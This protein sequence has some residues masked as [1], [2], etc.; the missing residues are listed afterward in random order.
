MGGNTLLR[1]PP[2]LFGLVV[3]MRG[4]QFLSPAKVT[5]PRLL[6]NH[7]RKISILVLII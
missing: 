5:M 4:I 7:L 6:R 3:E 2:V 1:T